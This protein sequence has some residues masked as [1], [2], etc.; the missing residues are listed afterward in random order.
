MALCEWL[1]R[2]NTRAGGLTREAGQPF[3]AP[4]EIVAPIGAG[5]MGEVWRAR[6]ERLGRDVAIK[7]LPGRAGRRSPSGCGASSRRRAPTG[8]LNHPNILAIYDVG[9][10]RARRTWSRSCSRARRCASGSAGGPLP[11]RKAIEVAVQVAHGPRGRPRQGHRP[12][13]PQAGEPL[14]HRGRARQDPR[15]RP[16]EA[17][18]GGRS[19]RSRPAEA[20]TLV[21]STEAGTVL[22]TVGYMAPEQVRGQAVRPP[23]GHLRVRLRAVRDARGAAGV[24]G[25]HAADTMSAILVEG[26]AAAHRPGSES[27]RRCRGSSASAWRSARRT[28]SRRRTTWHWR[29]GRSREARKRRRQRRW[30]LRPCDQAGAARPQRR[31]WVS[32]CWLRSPGSSS[33]SGRWARRPERLD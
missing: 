30:P 22:G 32:Y 4:Y 16:G 5:G 8:A 13:R 28:G 2:Y 12:P 3:S 14:R 6:D 1:P 11:A 7:V 25:R 29:C 31:S 27:R 23:G 17:R 33:S 24:P 26:A 19:S 21:Q 18:R 9:S 20:S 15:L 10:T